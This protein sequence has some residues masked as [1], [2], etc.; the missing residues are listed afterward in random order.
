MS[1][2]IF[3]AK[4]VIVL[5]FLVKFLRGNKV[6]WGI[7]LLTVTSAILFDT[8]LDTFDREQMIADLGFFFYIISGGLFAG[9]AVWL[10]GLLRPTTTESTTTP[11]NIRPLQPIVVND[12]PPAWGSPRGGETIS[13]AYDRQMLYNQI[14]YRFSPDDVLD[15]MF[16]LS[17][18]E[19]DVI[20][21]NQEIHEVI[22]KIIDLAEDRGQTGSLTLAV[23]RILTPIPRETLPRLEKINADS[24]QT[25]LRYYLIANYTLGEL[26]AMATELGID[27]QIIGGTNKQSK[28]RNL[29][30][31]LYRRNRL[32]ELIELMQQPL[33]EAV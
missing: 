18:N 4:I 13:T 12:D 1:V 7:G 27:W 3:F 19:N 15:L 2:L 6:V 30:L 9:A 16:D 5:F 10:W 22:I 29:L 25:V 32:E 17:I 26:E 23:E 28:V 14:R 11:A 21:F 24:S 8:F 31:F 33:H 20:S